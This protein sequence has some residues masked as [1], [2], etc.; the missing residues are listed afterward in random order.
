M[1]DAAGRD[2][3]G[4]RLGRN[5]VVHRTIDAVTGAETVMES[6]REVLET[7]DGAQGTTVDEPSA[8]L[9]CGHFWRPGQPL[10]RCDECSRKA[11][12]TV[13]ICA[14]C[15]VQCQLCGRALCMEH[16]RPASGQRY[17]PKCLRKLPGAG[18]PTQGLLSGLLSW[19]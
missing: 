1:L 10:A 4:R 2:L 11:R 17:C 12:K 5:V 6:S 14:A 3:M 8:V 18:T 9:H 15:A 7:F 16:T 19:W 13:Y